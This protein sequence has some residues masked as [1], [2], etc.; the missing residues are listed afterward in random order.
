[1]VGFIAKSFTRHLEDN[2]VQKTLTGKGLT[3]EQSWDFDTSLGILRYEWVSQELRYGRPCS[4]VLHKAS[5]R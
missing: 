1:M 4:R 2:Y 5:V 3:G